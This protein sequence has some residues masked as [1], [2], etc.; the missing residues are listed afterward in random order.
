MIHFHLFWII[1]FKPFIFIYLVMK[2]EY[3]Q[4][5]I[6]FYCRFTVFF[7]VEPTLSP[8]SDSGSVGIDTHHSWYVETLYVDIQFSQ[9]IYNNSFGN[10]FGFSFFFSSEVIDDRN[11]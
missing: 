11:I 9:W 6:N 7:V 1:L 2:K 4:F 8:P 10:G 3:S 5:L